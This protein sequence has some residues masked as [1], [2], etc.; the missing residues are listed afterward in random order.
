MVEYYKLV[1]VIHEETGLLDFFH[2]S[3]INIV[4]I[5]PLPLGHYNG[6]ATEI[7]PKKLSKYLLSETLFYHAKT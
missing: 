7:Y 2:G 5:T 1:P 3:I 6:F 4:F